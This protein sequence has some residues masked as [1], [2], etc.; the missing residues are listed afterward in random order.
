MDITIY[1]NPILRKKAKKIPLDEISSYASI[2]E[3]MFELMYE[4]NGIGLAAEQVGL[5]SQILVVDCNETEI[6]QLVV[7]NPKIVFKS[8]SK[9]PLEE[10]CLSFPGITAVIL[11]PETI[12]LEYYD[13][14][15]EHH[16]E[17]FS[18]LIAKVLQH[19]IDHLNGIL[20]VDRMSRA[21]RLILKRKLNHLKA[22]QEGE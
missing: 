21:Q 13:I 8:K 9:T 3:E 14:K 6:N 12:E 5:E 18:G 15:G 11:R 2:A 17:F 10:G 7:I 20:I 16:K 4:S 22:S 1:G 19:E